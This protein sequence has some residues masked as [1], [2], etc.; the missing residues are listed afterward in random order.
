[1]K[2]NRKF[3]NGEE[4]V[5][6]VIGVI[7]MVAIT[8]AIAATVYIWV[9]G[10]GGGGTVAPSLNLVQDAAATTTGWVNFTVLSASGNAKWSDLEVIVNGTKLTYS[11]TNSTPNNGYWTKYDGTSYGNNAPDT[12]TAGHKLVIHSSTHA[13]A[14]KTIQIRH[15]P[16]NTIIFS[17]TIF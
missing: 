14:G 11:S 12:L 13:K 4:A 1:M 6:A 3:V 2:A 16:S 8:V 15:V 10:L 17:K 7:L 5:S 9:S